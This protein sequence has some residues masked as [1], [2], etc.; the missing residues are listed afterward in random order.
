MSLKLKGSFGPITGAMKLSDPAPPPMITE[1]LILNLNAGNP[2]SYSGSG[3]TWYDTSG[4]NRHFT[5]NNNPSF[6]NGSFT[7]D[8]INQSASTADNDIWNVNDWTIGAWIKSTNNT[9]K[10][11]ALSNYGGSTMHYGLRYDH[12]NPIAYYDD[13]ASFGFTQTNANESVAS[14]TWRY[15]VGTFAKGQ[16][17]RVY[18]DGVMKNERTSV[19]NG[20]LYP[21]ASL[22]VARDT[23][24][25]HTYFTGSIGIINLYNQALTTEEINQNYT[26]Q[27]LQFGV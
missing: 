4:S 6:S 18:I 13:N 25:T 5:L 7:F 10:S 27:R 8:G 15:I 24:G 1:G 16:F 20:M 17:H 3:S 23:A 14:G 26:A 2:A 21:A 9:T 11:A 12:G 22:Y 19:Y